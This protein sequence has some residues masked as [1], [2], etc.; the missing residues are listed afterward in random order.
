MKRFLRKFEMNKGDYE[1][2]KKKI[3]IFR[4]IASL[5]FQVSWAQL[6]APMLD[7]GQRNFRFWDFFIRPFKFLDRRLV[8]FRCIPV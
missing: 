4:E 6:G 3:Q 8:S 2:N 1:T 7:P 5:S